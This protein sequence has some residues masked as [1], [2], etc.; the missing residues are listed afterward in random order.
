MAS[1]AVPAQPRESEAPQERGAAA[2]GEPEPMEV[3]GG[4][5]AAAV[6]G[7]TGLAVGCCIAAALSWERP[8]RSLGGFVCANLLFWFVALTPWRVYHLTS[9]IILGVLIFQI[10][11]D[12]VFSKLQG[13]QLWRAITG[14]I[15]ITVFSENEC[16]L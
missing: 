9:L 16:F 7:E 3:S 13:A 2:P 11:K 6:L 5:G 15:I 4:A 12:L 8:L 1:A 10:M 14:K